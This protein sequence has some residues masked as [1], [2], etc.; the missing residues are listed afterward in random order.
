M[1]QHKKIVILRSLWNTIL[2]DEFRWSL[3]EQKGNVALPLHACRH[4]IYLNRSILGIYL[5]LCNDQLNDFPKTKLIFSIFFSKLQEI[6][7]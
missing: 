6:A 5:D 2:L 1:F 3:A 7:L 4:S